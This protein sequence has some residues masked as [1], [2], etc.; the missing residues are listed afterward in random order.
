MDRIYDQEDAELLLDNEKTEKEFPDHKGRPGK[1]G[2]S[3]P[4]N[5]FPAKGYLKSK[6]EHKG[7]LYKCGSCGKMTRDTG[8]GE[9]EVE[10][11]AKCYNEQMEE[12][13]KADHD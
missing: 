12:N 11:C 9:A 1:V 4:K 13:Y 8:R 3:L 6:F 7:K 2:G 5:T 10:L